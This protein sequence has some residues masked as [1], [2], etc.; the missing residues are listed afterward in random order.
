MFEA[1]DG[2]AGAR[3]FGILLPNN[4]KENAVEEEAVEVKEEN[5]PKRQKMD[6]PSCSK[7]S[8]SQE[9]APSE[10]SLAAMV[11]EENMALRKINDE[12][13]LQCRLE[14]EKYFQADPKLLKNKLLRVLREVQR[15]ENRH[16]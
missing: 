11:A 3:T 12:L 8:L 10:S 9:K 5:N 4:E 13:R 15:Y 2:V 7:A 14:F 16:P 1:V 6:A